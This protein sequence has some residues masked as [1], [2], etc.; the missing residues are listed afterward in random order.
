MGFIERRK[1]TTHVDTRT[2]AGKLLLTMGW[3]ARPK[4]KGAPGVA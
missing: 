2:G 1:N 4:K 3:K